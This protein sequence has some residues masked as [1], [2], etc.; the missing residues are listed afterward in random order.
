MGAADKGCAVIILVTGT[1]TG[2]GKT[3]VAAGLG[4]LLHK[5]RKRV[6]AIKPVESGCEEQSRSLED[7][8]ILAAHT[9]QTEYPQ[10]LQRF[11]APLAPPCAADLEGQ[12]LSITPWCEVIRSLDARYDYVLVEGAGGLLSPLTWQHT[13][14]DLAGAVNARALVV[15]PDRL[16]TLN[17]CLLTLSALRAASVPVLGTVLVAPPSPDQ[18]THENAKTLRKF[19]GTKTVVTLSRAPSPKA[20]EPELGPIL[21]W[22]ETATSP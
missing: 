22:L 14:I 19:D 9:G 12:V 11:R 3:F 2:I 1:D 17:H 7:G 13:A 10:A 5:Q 15:A 6:I 21:N 4:Y 18:S 20:S 16:G 8:A